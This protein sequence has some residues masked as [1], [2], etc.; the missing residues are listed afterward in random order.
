MLRAARVRYL[1]RLVISA[2]SSMLLCL[3]DFDGRWIAKVRMD[4]RHARR[5][6]TSVSGLPDPS[7]DFGAWIAFM[8]ASRYAWQQLVAQLMHEGAS[9]D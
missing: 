6:C 1:R 2:P 8:K 9:S 3:L 7:H 5:I 4:L